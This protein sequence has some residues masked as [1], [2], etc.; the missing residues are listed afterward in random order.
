MTRLKI[1]RK[2]DPILTEHSSP[3]LEHSSNQDLTTSHNIAHTL[4]GFKAGFFSGHGRQPKEQEI[5][6]HAIRSWRD[7][8]C[9]YPDTKDTILP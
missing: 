7:L 8:N 2:V 6:N 3:T 4:A 5:W 9:H 1:P